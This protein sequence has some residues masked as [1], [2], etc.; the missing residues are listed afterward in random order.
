M[1]EGRTIVES[2]QIIIQK[3]NLKFQDPLKPLSK[4]PKVRK[5]G[6]RIRMPKE[7]RKPN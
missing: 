2:S 7:S 5:R 1:L 6:K 3:L 4:N